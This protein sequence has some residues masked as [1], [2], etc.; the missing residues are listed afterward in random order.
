M[1]ARKSDSAAK[2]EV[3]DP[4]NDVFA[5]RVPKRDL[6]RA[7]MRGHDDAM[8][9][10]NLNMGLPADFSFKADEE[11]VKLAEARDELIAQIHER[12]EPVLSSDEVRLLF[13]DSAFREDGTF[14]YGNYAI[15]GK[16]V[17]LA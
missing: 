12:G 6:L 13:G 5:G 7:R 9:E 16:P 3:Y 17:R 15:D 2:P 4:A 11:A 14:R 1:A 10:T 8:I